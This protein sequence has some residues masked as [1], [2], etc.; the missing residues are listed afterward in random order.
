MT[1]ILRWLSL[2]FSFL[3]FTACFEV[4]EEIKLSPNRSGSYAMV[5]EFTNPALAKF[6]TEASTADKAGEANDEPEWT[7]KPQI[8]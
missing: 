7:D 3:I 8:T 5:F 6:A 1:P 4:R 2:S